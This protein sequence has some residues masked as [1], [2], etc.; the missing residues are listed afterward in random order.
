MNKE[1]LANEADRLLK[2]VVFETAIKAVR[3]EALE[4][5][6]T[7]DPNETDEIRDAQAIVRTSEAFATLLGRMILAGKP[8]PERPKGQEQ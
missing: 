3:Q 5:L 7:V 8:S 1:A 4:R 6:A 2:D